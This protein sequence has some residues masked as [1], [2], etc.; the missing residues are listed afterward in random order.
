MTRRLRL[1]PHLAVLAALPCLCPGGEAAPGQV[2]YAELSPTAE[3]AIERGLIYLAK[4]QNPDG[5]WGQT[6]ASAETAL[7]L[8]AFMLKGQFPKRGV[9]GNQVEKAVT[10]LIR[11]GIEGKGYLGGPR[12][13]M[14]EHG[15][16]TLALAEVWGE[17]DHRKEIR[18]VL[19]Q[20]VE[21]ILRS[22][23]G[24]GGWR[25]GPQPHDADI[26]V[27]VMQVVALASAK[28]AGILVPDHVFQKAIKYVRSCQDPGTGGFAYT[29]GG[30]PGVA[31]AAGGVLSLMMAGERN[32]RNVQ[33]GL[34]YLIKG[35]ES[36]FVSIPHYMYG[37][38][39]AI[40]SMY[41]AGEDF[42]QA[43]YP[44]IR[45]VLL[46]RQRSDGCWQGENGASPALGTAWSILILGVPYRYLPIYQR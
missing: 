42:Y 26:S 34:E 45:N 22:Q 12:Q 7:A 10:Y 2:D 15:L 6:Y 17:S 25:Y 14:Y 29:P 46:Q 40:Q 28:E 16:G 39:Y 37:H 41:Q 24:A 13:G 3:Q 23:N 19:K 11:R 38:Y 9:F 27:T 44:K 8:M 20:A 33:R 4:T 30:A 18:E 31:R 43:W 1:L 21:V 32:S 36:K 5:S 35:P